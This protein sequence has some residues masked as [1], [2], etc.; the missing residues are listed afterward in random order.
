MKSKD[1]SPDDAAAAAPA[2]Y[3]VKV[4]RLVTRDQGMSFTPGVL[5][6]VSESVLAELGDA[7]ATVEQVA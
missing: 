3:R 6:V 7:V 1:S 5:Y 4:R 2:R